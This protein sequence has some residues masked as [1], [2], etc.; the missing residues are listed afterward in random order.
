[1]GSYR[2]LFLNLDS[3]IHLAACSQ[4]PLSIRVQDAIDRMKTDILEFGNPWDIWLE[5]VN[6]SKKLFAEIIH[7]KPENIAVSSSVSAA[8]SS[9]MSSLRYDGRNGI[10]VTSLDYPTTNFIALANEKNGARVSTVHDNGGEIVPEDYEAYINEK[11]K[12]VSA[13]HVSS[14]NGYKQDVDTIVQ[15]AHD[16]GAMAYIDAYQSVGS[17]E[18]DAVRTDAEFL[19]SGNL[20][21]LLGWS[22]ISHLY[23]RSDIIQESEPSNTGWFSQK[24]PFQFAPQKLEFADSAARFEGGTWSMP[25]VYASIAGMETVL[26]VGLPNIFR[27]VRELSSFAYETGIEHGLK[28]LTTSEPDQRGGIISFRCRDASDVEHKLKKEKIIT[29]ARGDGIRI[30]PHFY[31]TEEEV[32]KAIERIAHYINSS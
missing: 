28:P 10:V 24:H 17:V 30:A 5:K 25:S 20:K 12:L 4:S 2:S 13:I 23:V 6:R 3:V 19:T 8:F 15:T 27:R 31:N 21:W 11:T 9:V 7:A 16:R 32:E 26:E 14:L 22:G 1:M 18:V 29:A